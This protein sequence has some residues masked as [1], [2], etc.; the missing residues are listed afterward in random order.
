MNKFVTFRDSNESGELHYY[1][2]QRDFPHYIARISTESTQGSLLRVTIPQ[3]N[4]WLVFAGTLRGAVIPSYKD[5][6]D[7]IKTVVLDMAD[8]YLQNR[9]SPNPKKYKK[10]HLQQDTTTS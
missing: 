1:I 2:L 6:M 9:I 5:V 7:E 3:Y 10:W 4:M 8:W